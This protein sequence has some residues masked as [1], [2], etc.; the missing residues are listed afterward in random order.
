MA[1]RHEWNAKYSRDIGEICGNRT[2]GDLMKAPV[3]HCC[4]VHALHMEVPQNDKRKALEIVNEG[5]A[6]MEHGPVNIKQTRIMYQ[7][8]T[9]SADEVSDTTFVLLL[10]GTT[11]APSHAVLSGKFSPFIKSDR[12][13]S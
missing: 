4:V 13:P 12:Q 2:S 11:G 3:M 6:G 1:C 10:R 5:R 7:T 9:V 8:D